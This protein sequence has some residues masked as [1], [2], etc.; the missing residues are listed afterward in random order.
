MIQITKANNDITI[1]KKKIENLCRFNSAKVDFKVGFYMTLK[2]TNITY[3]E[4]FKCFITVKNQTL[5]CLFFDNDTLYFYDTS[6]PISISQLKI[7]I[8]TIRST[9]V[10]P[11]D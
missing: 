7:I 5:V 10:M 4:P 11:T 8:N 9:D 6:T 1:I 3:Y 2:K